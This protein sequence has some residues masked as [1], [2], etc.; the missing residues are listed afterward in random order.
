[1]PLLFSTKWRRTMR[2]R[3]WTLPGRFFKRSGP[4]RHLFVEAFCCL[5]IARLVLIAVAFRY[6]AP[7]LG[8]LRAESPRHDALAATLATRI[9]WAV[10]TA[11]RFTPWKSPCLVQAIAGK[12][13]L[14]RRKI[15]STLYLGVAKHA[16]EGLS[17]HAWLRCGDRILTGGA[18]KE[19][20]TVVSTFG[21]S[22]A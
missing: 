9:S 11:G 16:N 2:F 17:A 10:Q 4:D 20:F 22:G 1:M 13:M 3:C 7:F 21:E 12:M 15:P 14:K 19:Q 18:L 5:A 6:I 8:Q